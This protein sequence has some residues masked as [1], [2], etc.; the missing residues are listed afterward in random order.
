MAERPLLALPRPNKVGPKAGGGFPRENVP[1]LTAARQNQRLGPKFDRLAQ[2]I[3]DPARLADLR[4]D[5]TAIVPERALVFEVAGSLPDFYRAM[6]GVSGLELLGEDEAE[7]APDDDFSIQDKPDKNVPARF[8]FTLP[9][10]RALQELVSLWQR[11]QRGETLGTGRTAWR[12]V[13]LHLHDVRA[14]GP[15]DRLTQDAVDDWKERLQVAPDQNIQFEVEFWFRDQD[16]R[17]ARAE[18]SFLEE[19]GRLGGQLLDS[20]Q[21]PPIRYHAALVEMPPTAIREL[22]QHPEVG[23]AAFDDIMVLRPQ[24]VV[25]EPFASEPEA[26]NETGVPPFGEA[27]GEP[28]AALF[29]GLPMAQHELLRGR[30]E[31]DDPDNCEAQYGR[32]T[33]Q[34]HGTAMASLILHGDLNDPHP[35]VRRRLYVRPVMVPQAVGL[36]ERQE[37]MPPGR[38]GVDLMWRAF[39][40]MLEG[41]GGEPPTAPTVRIVNL[42]LGDAKRRFAGVMS[43]WARLIDYFAWRYGLLILISAGNISDALPL[44]DTATWGGFE[45]ASADDRQAQV[46]RSILQHR[47][48]RR[49]LSPSEAINALT[50]GA[51]HDD[52]VAPNGSPVLAVAPYASAFLPNP[53]SALGLGFKR[54]VKPELLFPGG[55]EQLR[56]STSHAPI[57]LR[58]VGSPNHYFGIKAAIPGT[59]GQTNS[60]ILHNGTSVATALATHSALRIFETLQELPS[61]PAYPRIDQ[62]YH[63]VILKALLI[64]AARWDEATADALRT[65]VNE[66]GPL[67]WEHER[68]ELTR[69]LGYGR[70]DIERVL[71]C[72]ESRATLIGWG[73]IRADEADQYRVPLPAGLEGVRGFRAVS[74]TVAWLTPLNLSHRMYRMAKLEAFPGSDK[75]FSLGVGRNQ[76]QPPPNATVRSTIFHQRWEGTKAAPFMDGG[77]LVVNVSC[78]SAADGLDVAV[79]YGLAVTLEV[80]SE[81]N[82]AVYEEI[83]EEIR[84]RLRPAV[85]VTT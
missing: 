83:R 30:L 35:P 68:E 79:P 64:H 34:R 2:T 40:R 15:K 55:R 38:L 9:D 50:V 43:P 31:I 77:D 59:T 65:L 49:L 3:P 74:I 67:Y 54:G 1:G 8:Y 70:P 11:L 21:I 63:A 41:E 26:V 56:S 17:R 7:I 47:A 22:L 6:R 44:P 29:D 85:R 69:F 81:I 61:D 14:W 39:L 60:V 42:S 16:T 51:C 32:A 72:A 53:T 66:N 4:G 33:E 12:D 25:G 62:N 48:A 76:C 28:V 58:P 78:K 75:A 80:G 71:D 18:R 52:Y 19:L 73:S 82:V 27:P 36:G 20:T 5:P 45:S 84:N 23:L 46:L 57:A 24:S 10:Q 37:F 13:F